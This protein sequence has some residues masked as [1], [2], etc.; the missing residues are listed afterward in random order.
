MPKPLRVDPANPQ[1]PPAS[2]ATPPRPRV[3]L[4]TLRPTTTSAP[5]EVTIDSVPA[6]AQVMR[7]GAVLGNTPFHGTL[8]RRDGAVTLLVRLAGYADKTVVIHPDHAVSE[9]I[10]LVRSAPAPAQKP[11]RDSSVNPFGN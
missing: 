4:P 6:G 7:S 10:K 1:P 2:V 8:P 9:R 5:V 11:N 3:V